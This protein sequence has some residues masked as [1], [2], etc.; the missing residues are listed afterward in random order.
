MELTYPLYFQSLRHVASVRHS[1]GLIGQDTYCVVRF[2]TR[3]ERV[4]QGMMFGQEVGFE[5]QG[6]LEMV[7]NS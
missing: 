1:L 2:A 3:G 5:G 7:M 4:R 6:D